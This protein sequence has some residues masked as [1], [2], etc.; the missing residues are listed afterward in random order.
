MFGFKQLAM[1]GV[2]AAAL[3]GSTGAAAA[4]DLGIIAFQMSSET[5]ARVANAAQAAAKEKGWKVTLLN[6]AGA[7]P[8]HA[9]QIENLTQA[10]VDALIIAMGK[11]IE[12]DAQL[13][14]AKDAKI[15]VVT[16]MS[17]SSP[18]AVFDIQ[19][20]EYQVGAQSALYLLGQ[21]RYQGNILEQRFDGNVGTRIRARVL[22]AVLAE[23]TAVKVLGTHSMARTAS[24]REDVKSGME[25][26][27]LKNQGKVDGIWASF[28]GQAYIIDDILTRS[29]ATKGKPVL[30]SIDGGEE[31]YRRIADPSS[32][33]MATVAIPFEEM[34]KKAV[35]AVDQIVVKK[36]PVE[37]IVQG[38]YLMMDAVLVDKTNVDKF[39]KK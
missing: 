6:S 29:G 24:W 23:N 35:D 2:A 11:P 17:G 15:P 7:M 19:V 14:A 21:L 30:V 32:T 33:L 12:A 22:D 18:H 28:D 31:T 37:Q 39:L 16:V 9:A 34:G 3:I 36:Q 38:P 25:A 10:K 20:N 13:K 5:H 8:D 27:L 1:A 4:F 26:L